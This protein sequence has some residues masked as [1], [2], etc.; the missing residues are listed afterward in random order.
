MKLLEIAKKYYEEYGKVLFEKDFPELKSHVAI[1]L[2]GEGS[3]CLRF[4]DE[5][6]K[7][8]DTGLGFTI[9]ID[10]TID[11]QKEFKLMRAYNSLPKEYMGCKKDLI[12]PVGGNRKGVVRLS[13]FIRKT[14]GSRDENVSIE[15]Y[16]RLPQYAMLNVTNGEVWYDGFGVLTKLRD[17]I[18]SMPKDCFLKRLA[19]NV[20]LM[21]QSGQYNFNRALSRGEYEAA[22]LAINEFIDSTFEVM[23][24][25]SDHFM[26]F[27]KWKFRMLKSFNNKF[28]A[29]SDDLYML[30]TTDNKGNSGKRK[31]DA[32]EKIAENIVEELK[33]RGI[34]KATCNDL[35]QHAIS[36]NDF[37]KDANIRNLN[38]MYCV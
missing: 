5:V 25:L 20:L 7:D 6:S 35:E 9:F 23:F 14:I 3:E 38:I 1:G 26:P 18:K 29:L 8:H 37:I 36:I 13:D 30:M 28:S 12:S 22:S 32:I 11:E 31:Q 34:T 4:D 15:Q 27:Y 21:N 2:I 10:D 33:N 17:N 24:L 19:G 16:L